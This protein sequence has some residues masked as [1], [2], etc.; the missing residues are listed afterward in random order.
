MRPGIEGNLAPS[1]QGHKLL[2]LFGRI[3]TEPDLRIHD[4]FVQMFSTVSQKFGAALRLSL[5]HLLEE[6]ILWRM[7]F[8][9]GVMAQTFQAPDRLRALSHGT[10]NPDAESTMKQLIPFLVA[11]LLAPSAAGGTGSKSART[12]HSSRNRKRGRG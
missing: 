3:H 10:I 4:L 11:G 7:H 1:G 8:V 9:I 12:S 5:P 6:E 2:K